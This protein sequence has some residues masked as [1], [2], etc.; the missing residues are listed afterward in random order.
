MKII[1]SQNVVLCTKY[2][3]RSLIKNNNIIL[4]MFL[5]FI[6]LENYGCIIRDMSIFLHSQG[7]ADNHG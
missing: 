2:E 6:K 1:F 4:I 7:H 5:G 3:K